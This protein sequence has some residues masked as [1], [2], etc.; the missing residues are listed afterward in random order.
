MSASLG[1]L[2]VSLR[3][4]RA[5]LMNEN[6]AKKGPFSFAFRENLSAPRMPNLDRSPCYPL[7]IM[8]FS[9]ENRRSPSAGAPRPIPSESPSVWRAPV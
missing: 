1:L 3:H 5:G 9:D 2:A 4:E 8:K 6:C 7:T